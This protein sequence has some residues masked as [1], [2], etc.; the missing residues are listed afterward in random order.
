MKIGAVCAVAVSRP[1]VMRSTPAGVTG[2]EPT[3]PSLAEPVGHNVAALGT[4]AQEVAEVE[5]LTTP[6]GASLTQDGE[7]LGVS[8]AHVARPSADEQAL[9]V[10]V[11]LDGYRHET[12][13][14][15]SESADLMQVVLRRN[16]AG[17]RSQAP[18]SP[19]PPGRPRP[20]FPI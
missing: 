5:I 9:E 13:T 18:A 2:D 6:P 11:R 20:K 14:I 15:T 3:A 19:V 12:L 8:P 10:H 17:R 16:R 7:P 4:P 1:A